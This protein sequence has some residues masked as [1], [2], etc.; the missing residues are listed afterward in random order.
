[1]AHHHDAAGIGREQAGQ[2]LEQRGLAGAVGAEQG[3][4]FA[5]AH[6]K[7]HAVDSA[8]GAVG[9]DDIV[10]QQGGGGFLLS[11]LFVHPGPPALV[12]PV[13]LNGA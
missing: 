2:Q 11:G 4:E 7:A 8:D 12:L 13:L 5:R 10:E 6:G 9:L 3:D 1:V